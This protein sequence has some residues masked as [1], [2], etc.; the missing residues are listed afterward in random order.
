MECVKTNK[1]QSLVSTGI[2][3]PRRLCTVETGLSCV[4]GR[5]R[6]REMNRKAC[7]STIW[8]LRGGKWC[9]GLHYRTGLPLNKGIWGPRKPLERRGMPMW[10]LPFESAGT[11][12]AVRHSLCAQQE[13][14][15]HNRLLRLALPDSLKLEPSHELKQHPHPSHPTLTEVWWCTRGTGRDHYC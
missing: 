15:I 10:S 1:N 3:C 4:P 8:S 6:E 12:C 14:C 2:T 5:S 13:P 7:S 11:S 9:W